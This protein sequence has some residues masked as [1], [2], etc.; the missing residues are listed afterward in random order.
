MWFNNTSS[1]YST[2]GWTMVSV[3]STIP[4][5]GNNATRYY[6]GCRDGNTMV[7]VGDYSQKGD[8]LVGYST[9][10]G[11][12]WN[13][14]DTAAEGIGV[15]SKCQIVNGMVYIVGADG[16]FAKLDLSKL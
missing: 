14:P 13:Y 10:G 1:P 7:A 16:L 6:G 5:E 9:D 11:S 4:T 8:G 2:E 3:S 15:L 12:T